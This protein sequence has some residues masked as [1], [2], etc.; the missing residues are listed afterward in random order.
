MQILIPIASYSS[1]FPTEDFQFPK[2]LVHVSG[3]PMIEVVVDNLITQFPDADFLFVADEELLDEFSLAG[4]LGQICSNSLRI[5]SKKGETQGGLCSCLLAIDAIDP[6]RPLL[7]ANSDQVIF[8]DLRQSFLAAIEQGYQGMVPVVQSVHPHWSYLLTNE[9]G[10][11]EQA[12]EKKVVSTN[13]I[14]GAY[15]FAKAADF[16]KAGEKVLLWNDTTN[17]QFFISSTLNQLILS[18][19]SIKM[20]PLEDD[21][22]FSF[23][24]PEAIQTY[25]RQGRFRKDTNGQMSQVN[26]L[27]PA[28]GN[29]SRFAKAGWK[30]P[31]PFIDVN[32]Q[33]MIDHVIQN[34]VPEGFAPKIILQRAHAENAPKKLFQLEQTGAHI[35][36]LD[37]ITEGTACTILEG[38][39]LFDNNSPLLVA[40]SDQLV[41]FD[42]E[43]FVRDCLDRQL[44]GSI[45]VFKDKEKDP[46]WSFAKTDKDGLVTEVAEKKAISEL[47]TVGIYFFAK[48]GDFIKAA[49]DMIIQNERVNNEFYTCPVYNY[50]IRRGHKIGVFEIEADAMHG[51]GTPEDLLSYQDRMGFAPSHDQPDTIGN[52]N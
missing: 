46:K 9:D 34:I 36:L 10:K 44:D 37:G 47:A 35:H 2:P 4:T 8:G 19:G 24:S 27:I 22:Y 38:A 6:D 13:A 15:F 1:F 28:A 3:K 21:D 18:G 49:T 51:L 50:M 11:V 40:N 48:A 25:Q 33:M 5:F 32:G 31:K 17:G 41:D 20:L 43:R 16:L 7:I 45:L 42:C 30:A 12:F 52:D 39:N 26:Y 29:G 23:F 14:A